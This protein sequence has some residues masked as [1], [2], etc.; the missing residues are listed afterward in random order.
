MHTRKKEPVTS[1][2]YEPSLIDRRSIKTSLSVNQTSSPK[3]YFH[4]NENANLK[5]FKYLEEIGMRKLNPVTF[6]QIAEL[7]PLSMP[8]FLF[9]LFILSM[10]SFEQMKFFRKMKWT[11]VALFVNPSRRSKRV[12]DWHRLTTI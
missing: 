1:A 7:I 11:L 10:N 3:P 12:V 4:L 2:S 8:V 5:M 6:H 9:S